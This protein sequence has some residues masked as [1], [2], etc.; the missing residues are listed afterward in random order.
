MHSN[1][2]KKIKDPAKYKDTFAFLSSMNWNSKN[3]IIAHLY[4]RTVSNMNKTPHLNFFGPVLECDME[5]LT[6]ETICGSRIDS[7]NQIL[8][9]FIVRIF[10]F[11]IFPESQPS[12]I[13]KDKT[14]TLTSYNIT[15]NYEL[16]QP[17]KSFSQWNLPVTL[18]RYRQNTHVCVRSTERTNYRI[19]NAI[20]SKSD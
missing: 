11:Q 17:K 14:I 20:N 1:A 2:K 16:I 9:N 12:E 4:N 5:L 3:C 7:F 6:Y 10:R 8:V 18:E 15:R 19:F 13:C